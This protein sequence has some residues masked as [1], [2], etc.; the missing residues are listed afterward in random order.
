M[1]M[2]KNYDL[3][4]HSYEQQVFDPRCRNRKIK[5][6]P[7]ASLNFFQLNKIYPETIGKRGQTN[8][9]L[10]RLVHQG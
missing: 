7:D 2:K 10:R 5:K 3:T 9:K 6:V 1:G 4:L 8:H